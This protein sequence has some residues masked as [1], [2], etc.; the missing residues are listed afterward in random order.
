MESLVV[1]PTSKAA[2]NQRS[3]RAGRV[4]P[5]KCFRLYTQWSFKHEMEAM[6]PPEILRTDMGNTVLMLKSLGI[7]DLVNFDFI[8]APPSQTLMNS[9]ELLYA[10]AAVNEEGELTRLGRRMA[11][12]PMEPC[13]SKMLLGGGVQFGVVAETL[14][15]ASM[16]S[17]GNSIFYTPKDKKIA[18]DHMR[19]TFYRAGGDH[20]TLLQVYLQWEEA[21]YSRSWC[22]DHFIQEKSMQRARDIREQILAMLEYVEVDLSSEPNNEVAVRKAVTSG[23]FKN[24]ARLNKTGSYTTIKHP[25]TV[26]IHPSSCLFHNNDEGPDKNDKVGQLRKTF[27]NRRSIVQPAMVLYSELVFTTAEYMRNVI[28]VDRKWLMELAPHYFKQ[29][30]MEVEPKTKKKKKKSDKDN[31]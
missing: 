11:Q 7:D 27:Q 26:N 19:R 9:L 13:Q 15:I 1:V 3:G 17:V 25:H 28:E 6:N 20:L 31:D 4:K 12:L 22:L 29:S 30:E 16:L 23:Y 14:T 2:A 18:A 5:G 21:N 24:C 10:L 8:D